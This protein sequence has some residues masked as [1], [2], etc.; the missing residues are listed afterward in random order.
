MDD[1]P[2]FTEFLEQ[3]KLVKPDKIKYYGY[4]VERF[5]QFCGNNRANL[6]WDRVSTFMQSL[7]ESCEDWQVRQ[8]GNALSIYTGNYLPA[9]H[10][11]EIAKLSDASR[12][13]TAAGK[14][15]WEVLYQLAREIG[16]LRR[17]KRKTVF[18]WGISNIQPRMFPAEVGDARS[19]RPRPV[20]L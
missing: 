11:I 12:V 10:G 8:A 5:V 1:K 13:P 15:S 19:R 14:S 7:E 16:K 6:T 9:V 3:R 17:L 18:P 2:K 4:W 20:R